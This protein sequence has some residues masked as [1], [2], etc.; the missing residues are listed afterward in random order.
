MAREGDKWRVVRGDCLWN[1]AKSVYNNGN[2]WTAI[3]DANGI[4]RSKGTIYAGQ[5]LKLPGITPGTSA[6][7]ASTPA[8]VSKNNKQVTKRWWALDADTDRQMYCVWEWTKD[9]TA[10]YSIEVWYDTGNG[11]GWRQQTTTS[12]NIKQYQVTFDSSAKKGKLRIKAYPATHTVNNKETNWWNPK[13]AEWLDLT[14]DFTQN[15]PLMPSVPEIELVNE[16]LTCS[17]SNIDANINADQIE[18]SVYKNNTTK[19]KTGIGNINTETR[20]VSFVFD[21]EPGGSYTVR[22]RAVRNKNIYSN[23]T[24]FTNPVKTELASFI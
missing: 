6:G 16:K 7:G 17:L 21:L 13:D 15:P 1:I 14:Y 23:W 18:F 8:A 10:G 9:H 2:K 19:Y 3:A 24:D 11:A 12:V 5:L 20:Y 4:N 22:C